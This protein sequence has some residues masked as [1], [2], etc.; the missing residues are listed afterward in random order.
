MVAVG[1]GTGEENVETE[2]GILILNGISGFILGGLGTRRSDMAPSTRDVN[3]IL[4]LVE[5]NRITLLNIRAAKKSTG[6]ETNEVNLIRQSLRK[7]L[8]ARLLHEFTFF[9][10]MY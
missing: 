3:Q 7:L 5:G 1:D 6:E 4:T 8:I 10:K 2:S 9:N